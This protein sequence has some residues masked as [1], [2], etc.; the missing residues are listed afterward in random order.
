MVQSS[1]QIVEL[2]TPTK[3]LYTFNGWYYGNT[4][5]QSGKWKIADDTELT[6]R[7]TRTTYQISFDT[8][9]GDPVE[10][11]T[12]PSFST[13][14]TLPTLTRLEHVFGMVLR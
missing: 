13:V 1:F 7:W 12:V 11:M 2:P 9:G 14:E 3:E 8:A 6:A 5:V 4:Q 10:A